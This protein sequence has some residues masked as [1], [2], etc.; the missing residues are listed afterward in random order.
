MS[1]ETQTAEPSTPA[2][3]NQ[4]GD[5]Q[6][7]GAPNTD[8]LL[9]ATTQSSAEGNQD[10][11]TSATGGEGEGDTPDPE[12]DNSSESGKQPAK[13]EIK[14]EEGVKVDPTVVA[15][16]ENVATELGLTPEQ[17]QKLAEFGPKL[18]AK[19]STDLISLAEEATAEWAEQSRNDEEIGGKGD[20]AIL[21]RN[22]ADASKA[23]EAFATP[24]LRSLLAKFDKEANPNGTGFGNHPEVIRLFVRIG[25]AISEDSTVVSGKG[26]RP[27]RN[28]EAVLYNS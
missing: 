10:A 27:V 17:A 23:M 7:Q 21:D 20:Q 24:E 12:G 6:Q 13:I 14:F 3:T 22:L 2:P 25:K 4:G 28:P 1:E 11:N 9:N 8:T 26:T 19:F 18:G 5:G 15:E 16:F